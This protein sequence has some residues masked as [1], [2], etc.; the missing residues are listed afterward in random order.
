MRAKDDAGAAGIDDGPLVQSPS[1]STLLIRRLRAEIESDR[2]KVGARFPTDAEIC[3]L[4]NVSRTVVR[5]AVASLRELGL[6][7]TRRGRGSV[8]IAHSTARPFSISGD[9]LETLDD[10]IRV[11]ELRRALEVEAVGLAALRRTD[12][13]L[14]AIARHLDELDRLLALGQDVIELDMDLHLAFTAASQNDYFHRVLESLRA[15]AVARKQVRAELNSPTLL[16]LTMLGGQAEHRRIEAAIRDR[17][18]GAAR[19]EMRR[20]LAA[21]RYHVLRRELAQGT[22]RTVAG[23]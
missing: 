12:A 17:D 4:F 8:V 23:G 18:A 13:D 3:R 2:L 11:Y 15:A 19:R 6:I 10:V 9:E 20:H 5:E 7:A 1:L 16:Q 14:A 21:R 22:V